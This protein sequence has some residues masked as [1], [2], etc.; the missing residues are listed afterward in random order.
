[1]ENTTAAL[2][3]EFS[4]CY[5]LHEIEARFLRSSAVVVRAVQTV[6]VRARSYG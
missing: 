2:D 3:K 4:T 5:G 1:M 6:H